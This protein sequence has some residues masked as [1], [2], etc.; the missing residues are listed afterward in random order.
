MKIS[1]ILD[2]AP[3][4]VFSRELFPPGSKITASGL[5]RPGIKAEKSGFEHGARRVPMNLLI[6]KC[7][8]SREIEFNQ[9]FNSAGNLQE[10]IEI[11][12][13]TKMEDEIL[14]LI[15][16]ELPCKMASIELIR[17]SLKG[18]LNLKK[19]SVKHPRRGWNLK[20]NYREM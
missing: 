7:S 9:K 13:K 18:L 8:R 3:A 5:G 10:K 19:L 4:V 20:D 14:P 11:H 15:I 12:T 1:E 17:G 16:N 2:T 6:T